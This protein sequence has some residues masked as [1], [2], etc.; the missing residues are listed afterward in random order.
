MASQSK[1]CR[2][3]TK[4]E[5]TGAACKGSHS[6]LA[7]QD[8][9]GM[10]WFSLLLVALAMALFSAPDLARAG[11][12][13]TTYTF[14]PRFGTRKIELSATDKQHLDE[15]AAEWQ[16]LEIVSLEVVGHTDN[17]PIAPQNRKE[18][19]NNQVLSEA[20]ARTVADYLAGRLQVPA[21]RIRV[22]GM[23]DRQP[24]A[25]NRNAGGRAQNR[26]VDVTLRAAAAA[27]PAS[28]PAAPA[29]AGPAVLQRARVLIDQGKASEAFRLLR[30]VES[31]MIGDSDYDYLYGLAALES[32]DLGEAM[33]ALQRAVE[34]DPGYAAARMELARAHFQTGDL[35]EAKRQFEMLAG[36]NPPETARAAI[37]QR[38]AVINR[39]LS[40]LEPKLQYYLRAGS[41][42]DSNAN[43]A[44]DLNSFLGF[45]LSEQSQETSSPFAMAGGGLRYLRPHS[46]TLVL[47][48]RLDLSHRANFDASFVDSTAAR[49]SVGLRQEKE[50]QVR[51]LGIQ[52]Y[53]QH[54]DGSLNSQGLAISGQ[55]NF[56]LDEKW[57][58]GVLGRIGTTRYGDSLKVKNVYEYLGGVSAAMR[59]GD[60]EQ[61]SFGVSVVYG[62][63]EPIE[64][65]S[66][67]ARDL[68][69]INSFLN[70]AFSG[71]L[72]GN[73]SVGVLQADYEEVFFPLQYSSPREDTLTQARLAAFWKFRP[74]WILNPSLAWYSNSTD[75]EIFEFDRF[76]LMISVSRV[77]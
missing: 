15:I 58:L 52:G 59:F 1:F 34:L 40:L 32:N 19:A 8:G 44:T 68:Y 11:M 13:E 14:S 46:A 56:E 67:Y 71:S 70:W 21:T 26:R 61:G 57:Q 69:G 72:Q 7:V 63:D 75:V 54:V 64:D 2:E 48:T 36:Q 76:E 17:I 50:T 28:L 45:D 9:L 16:G 27:V 10:S 53:R 51:S 6:Q 18:F 22:I 37:L 4:F 5:I 43:S 35:P 3:T 55:W 62:M 25:S 23:G 49:F 73:L 12:D 29:A 31:E 38:L 33:F 47:D 65:G 66:R 60:D 42:Y 20:R 41:G 74:E 39:T 24:V 77:W 30:T